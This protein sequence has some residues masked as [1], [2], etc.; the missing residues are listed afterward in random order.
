M[1]VC[2]CVCGCRRQ[3]WWDVANQI[4]VNNES[5]MQLWLYKEWH[6]HTHT[7]THK[8]S[9]LTR[10]TSMINVYCQ[11]A[12]SHRWRG[13]NVS[14]T[15]HLNWVKHTHTHTQRHTK[16]SRRLCA[17][18]KSTFLSLISLAD[19]LRFDPEQVLPAKMDCWGVR[20]PR[21]GRL[22][23]KQNEISVI[24]RKQAKRGSGYWLW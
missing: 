16:Q 23:M 15:L 17:E 13:Y 9:W 10:R 6:S 18:V 2:V 21:D 11:H 5:K 3:R 14:V 8:R 20:E 4:T 19:W 1:C 24:D 22:M 12:V 7:R